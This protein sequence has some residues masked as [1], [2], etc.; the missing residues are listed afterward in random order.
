[1]KTNQTFGW[2]LKLNKKQK[3]YLKNY[4]PFGRDRD[5]INK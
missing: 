1:M 3:F 5:F 2:T 4:N